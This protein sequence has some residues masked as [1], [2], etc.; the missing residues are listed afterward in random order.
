MLETVQHLFQEGARLHGGVGLVIFHYVS[1]LT[2]TVLRNGTLLSVINSE[3][4]SSDFN[5][6][7][8]RM[9]SRRHFYFKISENCIMWYTFVLITLT[10]KLICHELMIV[11]AMDV[12]YNMRFPT[13][14]LLKHILALFV[15]R[16]SVVCEDWTLSLNLT[17]TLI[18]YK[19]QRITL[20]ICKYL[21]KL[22][23]KIV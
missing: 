3:N 2:E 16:P 23:P 13:P 15:L 20:L 4:D 14:S 19:L 12:C 7:L 6:A 1:S 11:S 17:I 22:F 5:K 10:G 21:S 18:W 8:T 9:C